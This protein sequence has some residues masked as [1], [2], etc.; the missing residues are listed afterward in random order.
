MVNDNSVQITRQRL[1]L[2]EEKLSGFLKDR[3][4]VREL[5]EDV[6][7]AL[8]REPLIGPIT[9]SGL[10]KITT[11]IMRLSW[12]KVL[13][14]QSKNPTTPKAVPSKPTVHTPVPAKMNLP[15]K[16]VDK[17]PIDIAQSPILGNTTLDF[18]PYNPAGSPD[19]K[20]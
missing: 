5:P 20:P 2:L 10:E 16:K 12:I 6:I 4:L 14:N 9:S 3:N 18:G 19:F 17:L 13:I 8:K 11:I 7:Q 15:D 1:E